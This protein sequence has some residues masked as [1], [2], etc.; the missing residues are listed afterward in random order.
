MPFWDPQPPRGWW[1]F[2]RNRYLYCTNFY[3][4]DFWDTRGSQPDAHR[5]HSGT[6]LAP[7]RRQKSILAIFATTGLKTGFGGLSGRFSDWSRISIPIFSG[8]LWIRERREL[9]LGSSMTKPIN[10]KNTLLKWIFHVIR[11]NSGRGLPRK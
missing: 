7:N 6:V 2:T 3:Q 10:T 8:R 11:G 4:V 9:W 1:F 5:D